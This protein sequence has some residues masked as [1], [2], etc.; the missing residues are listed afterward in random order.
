V[1][2]R[3]CG[4]TGSAEPVAVRLIAVAWA[5]TLPPPSPAAL[6]APRDV[7]PRHQTAQPC[8]QASRVGFARTEGSIRRWWLLQR[9]PY[10]SVNPCERTRG[11]NSHGTRI[12][13]AAIRPQSPRSA[14]NNR[15]TP[16]RGEGLL[17]RLPSA[18]S[19]EQLANGMRQRHGRDE[20]AD[21]KGNVSN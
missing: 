1:S 12:P 7:D 16:I 15:S 21:Q 19:E 5:G 9:L 18:P 17:A 8:G 14:C 4:V 11:A 3:T 6:P 13:Q 20:E 2:L 10:E